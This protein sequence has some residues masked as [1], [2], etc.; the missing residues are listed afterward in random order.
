MS[1]LVQA[2]EYHDI[3]LRS[4]EKKLFK[5]VNNSNGIKFPIKVDIAMHAHK[6]SLLVQS[7]LG[8][9]EYPVDDQYAKHK[10][11]FQTE[12][13]LLFSNI[14]RLIRCVVDIQVHLQD[15]VG[16]R[17]A[18]ELARSLSAGVW[19]NSPFQM[20]QIPQIGPISIRKL[21]LGGIAS[22]EAL[23]AAEPHRIEM[24]LSKN[25][26]FGSKLVG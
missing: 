26:P 21:L 15:A 18:L 4:F 24:L 23:E 19:D 7:E 5:E 25:P 17:H 20:K 2:E 12:R 11:T 1:S 3:R 14:H 9:V 16:A 8:G 10:R 6:R 22:I 13:N